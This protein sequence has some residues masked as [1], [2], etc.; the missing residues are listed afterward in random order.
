MYFAKYSQRETPYIVREV[1]AG[2]CHCCLKEIKQPSSSLLAAESKYT[3]NG[4]ILAKT[5]VNN[6]KN[7]LLNLSLSRDM[8]YRFHWYFSTVLFAKIIKAYS[9]SC[10]RELIATEPKYTSNGSIIA[11][12]PLDNQR[13]HY[14]AYTLPVT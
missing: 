5:P 4:S 6:Q 3:S 7:T 9:T 2:Y 10:F 14:L 11:K 12:T 8:E 13:P 1:P